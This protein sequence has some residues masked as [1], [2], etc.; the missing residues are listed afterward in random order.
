MVKAERLFSGEEDGEVE[1]RLCCVFVREKL[2]FGGGCLPDDVVGEETVEGG[3][4]EEED[5]DELVV[6]TPPTVAGG[7]GTALG[8][9]GGWAPLDR[10][11]ES[12]LC[13][14]CSVDVEEAL[15]VVV[16]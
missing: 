1:A 8:L 11:T 7:G 6:G 14:V 15:V 3:G 5:D 4:E 13:V 12:A 16:G 10:P 9:G 2:G